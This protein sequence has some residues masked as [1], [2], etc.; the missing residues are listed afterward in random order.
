[1]VLMTG[2][3]WVKCIEKAMNSMLSYGIDI[4]AKLLIV[5]SLKNAKQARAKLTRP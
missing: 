3:Y 2:E 1:M 5:V 4:I